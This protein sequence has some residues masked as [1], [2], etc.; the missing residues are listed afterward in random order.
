METAHGLVKLVNVGKPKALE[1]AAVEKMPRGYSLGIDRGI[2]E[3][4][5]AVQVYDINRDTFYSEL[6]VSPMMRRLGY[7]RNPLNCGHYKKRRYLGSKVW[8]CMD[9]GER[10]T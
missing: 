3:D 4:R 9:C 2:G 8:E 7:T 1:P 6:E 5:G 10:L